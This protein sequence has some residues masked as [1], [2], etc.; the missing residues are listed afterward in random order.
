MTVNTRCHRAMAAMVG[1]IG[2]AIIVLVTYA[3]A[4]ASPVDSGTLP[5]NCTQPV[6]HGSAPADT[7]CTNVYCNWAVPC[8][9]PCNGLTWDDGFCSGEET[10]CT[11]FD[12]EAAEKI[13]LTCTCPCTFSTCGCSLGSPFFEGTQ[14][15]VDCIN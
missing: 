5:G 2:L 14:P 13:C 11:W 8:P 6:R 10:L 7:L 15:V 3:T 4:L 12:S 9:T 1:T